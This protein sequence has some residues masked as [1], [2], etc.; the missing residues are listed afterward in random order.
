MVGKYHKRIIIP[1]YD[2]FD[3]LN[4]FVTR[5]FNRKIKPKYLNPDVDKQTIIFNY[6]KINFDSTIYLVEGVFDHIVVPNSIPLLGKYVS[7]KLWLELQRVNGYIVILLDSDAVEDAIN[8]YKKLNTGKLYGRIRI[9]VPPDGHD[10]ST[11]YQNLGSKGIKKLI[12]NSYIPSESR[13]Y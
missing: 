12:E 13:I 4:Y 5:S 11:I 6:G 1:S 9:N 2:E 7:D 3:T 10:P 8:I